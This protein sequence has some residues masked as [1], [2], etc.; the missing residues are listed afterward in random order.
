MFI[1]LK[2]IL[3]YAQSSKWQFEFAGQNQILEFILYTFVVLNKN[4][5][6]Y[7]CE[8]SF[9]SLGQTTDAD[10]EDCTPS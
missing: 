8:Q 6:I 3:C 1:D 5:N 10:H 4:W 9:T 7:W 2:S